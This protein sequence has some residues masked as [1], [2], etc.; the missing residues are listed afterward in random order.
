MPLLFAI[1]VVAVMVMIFCFSAE[2]GTQSMKTS[3]GVTAFVLKIIK[4][5]WESMTGAQ[6]SEYFTKVSHYVRKAAHFT[7]Y[8]LLGLFASLLVATASRSGNKS[9][10]A[11]FLIPVAIG[12]LYALFDEGHQR[13]VGGRAAQFTDVIIDACGALVATV[14]VA[15]FALLS[16]RKN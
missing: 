11:L 13:Y 9:T 8:F 1:L 2:N 7:E 15:L 4:P 6:K 12:F 16:R 3:N 14:L 5:D 10:F